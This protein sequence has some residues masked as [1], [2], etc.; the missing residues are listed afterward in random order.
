[1]GDAGDI[2]F[3]CEHATAAHYK[4]ASTHARWHPECA[5]PS[6]GHRPCF[7]GELTEQCTGRLGA[8]C[9]HT[10]GLPSTLET[11]I[12]AR[13]HTKQN[14]KITQK[15]E[16]KRG[17]LFVEFF[18][19]PRFIMAARFTPTHSPSKL[20]FA[21]PCRRCHGPTICCPCRCP[22]RRHRSHPSHLFR[23]CTHRTGACPSQRPSQ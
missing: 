1:M 2:F 19:F 6:H 22:S 14:K 10:S 8:Q 18:S 12:G 7:R 5:V 23:W 21:P 4:A 3:R 17:N 15:E 11:N 9:D 20:P 16:D 13:R